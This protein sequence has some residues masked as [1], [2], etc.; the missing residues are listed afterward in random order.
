MLAAMTL[1]VV[2]IAAAPLYTTAVAD[3]ARPAADIAR[4]ADRKPAAMLAF[5]H[6]KPGETIV[7]YI[8]GKGYFTRLFSAAVGPRGTV[9]AATPQMLIDAMTKAG[10]PLP[11]S[12]T[13][14]A[15]RGNVHDVIVS[16]GS[17]HVPVKVDLI[18]TAQNYHDVHIGVGPTG[19]E[20][21]DKVAFDLLKPG[22]YFVVVDHAGAAGLDEA[23]TKT[24]HRIDEAVV[25]QEV[26]AAGFVLDGESDVL[27][28]LADP[29]SA[30]V[31]DPSIRGHTDQFV[32]R[33]RKP[34]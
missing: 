32:L 12:V 10:F 11:P 13:T 1:P 27:R 4:D 25:K 9:Y 17:F 34:G 26:L 18:W 33:F 15:G 20:Y 24:L 14:E 8:P 3:P 2:A 29:H 22:G 6:V 16:G 23:G 7:D 30:P 19:A 21:L 28:N 31:F 5:A